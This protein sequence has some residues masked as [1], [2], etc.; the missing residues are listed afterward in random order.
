M[1]P[2]FPSVEEYNAFLKHSDGSKEKLIREAN[3]AI[4]WGMPDRECHGYT[5]MYF[6]DLIQRLRNYI[7]RN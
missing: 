7:E 1:K 2:A 4:A 5:P 6:I 3:E